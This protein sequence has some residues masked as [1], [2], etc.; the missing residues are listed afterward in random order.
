MF[1]SFSDSSRNQEFHGF[2]NLNFQ[3][4]NEAY[5]FSG[6]TFWLD[7]A[8][9]LNTQ[10]NLGA[11]SSWKDRIGG[12][13]FVQ[14]TAGNQ[15]RLVLSDADFN[16]YPSIEFYTSV[17]NLVSITGG[18]AVNNKTTMVYVFKKINNSSATT[19]ANLLFGLT[20]TGAG[21]GLFPRFVLGTSVTSGVGYSNG[22]TA[23][24]W[25]STT[26]FDTNS[27]IIIVN[28]DNYIDNGT[29]L[30]PIG[31]YIINSTFNAING[32]GAQV[33]F[34]FKLA[35]IISINNV[36][37][38]MNCIELSNRINSKYAIY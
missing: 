12:I 25:Y 22:A 37:D 28:K 31:T 23:I 5:G 26:P 36:L 9:G 30:T 1:K 4:N 16:N 2:P 38:E 17:R 18:C 3:M 33:Q 35:E 8:Y 21:A 29:A 10:T 19:Y 7:A 14:A 13:D 32:Q 15:P 6:C 27:H 20:S 24:Q 34:T 11:V